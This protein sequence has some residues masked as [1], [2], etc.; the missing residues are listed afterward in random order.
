MNGILGEGEDIMKDHSPECKMSEELRDFIY[1]TEEVLQGICKSFQQSKTFQRSGTSTM[2]PLSASGF[3]THVDSNGT[4]IEDW[5]DDPKNIETYCLD[6]L[7]EIREINNF[8]QT[9][10]AFSC[11]FGFMGFLSQFAGA[12]DEESHRYRD[13][14]VKYMRTL[15]CKVEDV[16]WK[17]SKPPVPRKWVSGKGLGDEK[18]FNTWSEILYSLGRCGLLHSLSLVGNRG[19]R[20]EQL[21]LRLTHGVVKDAVTVDLFQKDTNGTEVPMK[22]IS[23]ET[24][25]KRITINADDLCD[26]VLDGI[27]QLFQD[28]DAVARARSIM[29]DRPA[30]MAIFESK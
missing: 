19:L 27:R 30:I 7:S 20:Q 21:D 18:L 12:D 4:K 15:R 23:T 3:G 24:E 29:Q 16:Q 22:V 2:G 1:P 26:S 11:I 5:F 10:S 6:R 8:S 13:L 25:V 9:P 14:T 28:P 17:D